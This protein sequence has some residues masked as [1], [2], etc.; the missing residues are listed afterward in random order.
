V[1]SSTPD[2]VAPEP[3]VDQPVTTKALRGVPWT[4]GAFALSRGLQLV[5]T[6]VIARLVKPE[7]IGVV[8]TGIL[9]VNSLNLLSD[10]G[11][12]ISLVVREQVDR[13]LAD[14]VFTLMLGIACVCVVAAWAL[15]GPISDAFGSPKLS[16]VL[17][18]LA[19]TVITSTITWYFTNMLQ[20]EMLW[21]QRFA[22][23]FALAIG[24]VGVAVPAA[25]LGAEVWS[26]VAGQLAAG[27]L[28]ALVL[29]RV[30]PHKVRPRIHRPEARIAIRESR[31]YVSQAATSFLS[32]NLHFVAVSAILGPSSMAL[33]SMSYRLSELP[34]EALSER[35]AEATLPAYVR[36]RD[37]PKRAAATLMTSLRYLLLV[38]L[39]PLA[40]LAATSPDFVAAVLGPHWDGMGPI[41]TTLCAW[42]GLAMVAGSYGWFLN[43][44]NGARFMAT[45]N[46]LRMLV[47]AP[48]IFAAAAVFDS[49]Q[50]VAFLLC[51]DIGLEIPALAVYAHR[52]LQVP[53]RGLLGALRLPLSAAAV[54]VVC[55]LGCRLGLDD[56]G[57]S[58]WPRLLLSVLA[59]VAGYA[60]VVLADRKAIPEMRGLARRA[61]AR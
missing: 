13:R 20:R 27:V 2:T 52:H 57:M 43:A 47:V 36:L 19:L 51:L 38:A 58:V 17:P 21:R 1:T 48:L 4:L 35:V 50:V 22:G 11:L 45:M 33:Y 37:Q 18:V 6:L 34:N 31:P 7:A 40:L 53:F 26:M 46:I 55:A 25:A 16:D 39:L 44:N 59:G 24:Y 8:L 23:Q 10:N 30:Y 60:V 49:L 3:P 61:L 42:G 54:A 28:A 56:A 12:S 32:E 29:W 5:G 9:I 15:A 14:T 41:L